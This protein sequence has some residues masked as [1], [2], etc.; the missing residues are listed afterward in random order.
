MERNQERRS[1]GRREYS[2][3]GDDRVYRKAGRE[4]IGDGEEFRSDQRGRRME[5]DGSINFEDEQSS[6][7]SSGRKRSE[8]RRRRESLESGRQ[9][10][11]MDR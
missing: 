11:D 4:R 9:R 5:D 7:R 6:T 8:S 3:I 1:R 10:S 2:G